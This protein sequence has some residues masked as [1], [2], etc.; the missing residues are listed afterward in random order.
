M[1][2]GFK[3]ILIIATASV[4]PIAL[5][6]MVGRNLVERESRAEFQ[7]LLRDG[8]V[9]V[10]ARFGQLQDD[11]CRSVERLA[12]PDDLFTHFVLLTRA[13]G[14]DATSYQRLAE[15]TPRVMASRGLD[16]LSV[17]G[18]DHRILASGHFPGQM[19]DEDPRAAKQARALARKGAVLHWERVLRKG[20]LGTV[21]TVQ[22]WRQV[23]TPLG[24]HLVVVGGKRLGGS[25]L[26][27][28]RL[29]GGTRIHIADT[30]GRTLAG[31]KGWSKFASYPRQVIPLTGP[32]G[33]VAAQAVLAVPDDELHR[34]L[35]A[36][37]VAAGVLAGSGLLFALLLGVFTARSFTRPFAQLKQAFTAVGS[38]D[39]DHRVSAQGS[40]EVADLQ[41]SF[42]S[43]ATSLQQEH[44][45]RHEAEQ[46]A[47]A[48]ERVAAWREIARRLAH[49]LRN[50]LTP[51]KNCIANLGSAYQQQLPRFD[52]MF[53]ENIPI[54]LEEVGRLNGIITAFS[55]FAKMPRPRLEP[56]DLGEVLNSTVN[57][58]RDESAQLVCEVPPELPRATADRGQ[59][60]QA[61]GNLIQNAQNALQGTPRPRVSVTARHD[62]EWIEVQVQDNGPGFTEEVA[63]ELFR[64]Y[65][66]T[67]QKKG[68]TGLGLAN[69]HRIITDHGG[70]IRASGEPGAGAV[71][72]FRLPVAPPPQEP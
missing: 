64:P 2:L 38:G 6:T 12:N 71:F 34:T 39:L 15:I 11:V 27:G 18:P 14:V 44:D 4:I 8:K 48:A 68:G 29:R 52:E 65:F 41:R 51:I 47:K 56:C 62:G 72:I 30:R 10:L 37:N 50:P 21:L 42:N 7:R 13:R 67:R 60:S 26:R 16:T 28:L 22:C 1:R 17:L 58:Y 57:L 70:S 66:T 3:L 24:G 19:G 54:V 45:K 23:S 46:R 33:K 40:G 36:M 31:R 49:D 25:L 20:K 9:E 55:E 61:L 5:V 59:I 53:Q 35:K 69:V 32:G 43:M 63:A